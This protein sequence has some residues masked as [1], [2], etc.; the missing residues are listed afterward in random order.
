MSLR[1]WCT[2]I[3]SIE[4]DWKWLKI[5]NQ[6]VETSYLEVNGPGHIQ[7]LSDAIHYLGSFWLSMLLLP[8]AITS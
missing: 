3:S 5:R 8:I 1:V 6:E 7:E 2:T 4:L